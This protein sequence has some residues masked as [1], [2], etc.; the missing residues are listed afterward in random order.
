MRKRVLLAAVLA[1]SLLACSGCTG[2]K[3]NGDG[4]GSV[5]PAQSVS[6]VPA[7]GSHSEE[8]EKSEPEQEELPAADFAV[9][10]PTE[11]PLDEEM[12]QLCQA[13]VNYCESSTGHRPGVVRIDSEDEEGVTLQLYDD[14]GDHTATCAWYTIDPS[15]MEGYDVI[16]GEEIAFYSYMQGEP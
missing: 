11:V 3:T 12:I 9:M 5:P 15:T 6:S 13:A 10:S 14:M 8:P 2:G 16:T 7:E 4:S 1:L